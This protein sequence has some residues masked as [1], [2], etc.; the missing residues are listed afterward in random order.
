MFPHLSCQPGYGKRLRRQAGLVAAA[1]T[2]L[3]RD[4]ASWD[5]DLRL[6]DSTPVPC[7]ASR[8]TVRRSAL[9][10]QVI[11]GDKG[12]ADK[13]FE[14]FIAGLGAV[15]L[16]PDRRDE[17]LRFGSPGKVRQWI[18][19]V[20]DTLKGLL[21]LEQHGGRTLAG[22]YARVA[23]RLFALAAGIWHNRLINATRKRSLTAYDH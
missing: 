15:L 3:A 4:A 19:F 16:R 23:A 21:T 22:V 13:G 17:P 7:E 14:A 1:I 12:F 2:A 8:E 10:G 9:A 5:G 20:F 18:E 11:L 6:I